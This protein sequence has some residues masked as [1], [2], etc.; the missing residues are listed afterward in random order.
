MP[1][2]SSPREDAALGRILLSSPKD[3]LEHEI[4][5][6]DLL[7]H[8]ANARAEDIRQ[9]LLRVANVNKVDIIGV[10]PERTETFWLADGRRVV[11]GVYF[12]RLSTAKGAAGLKI[13]VIQ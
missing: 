13:V 7:E 10:R 1:R 5:L 2:G 11:T 9:R 12:I 3:S 4:V 6:S 8:L